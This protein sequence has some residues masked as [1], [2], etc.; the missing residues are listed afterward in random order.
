M[1]IR[2]IPRLIAIRFAYRET[3]RAFFLPF[4]DPVIYWAINPI[5]MYMRYRG[6]IKRPAGIYA[7]S[8]S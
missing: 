5:H 2:N 1:Y 8:V 7:C 6:V 3:S 4:A